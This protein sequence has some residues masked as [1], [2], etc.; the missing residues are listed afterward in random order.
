MAYTFLGTYT[1][2]CTNIYGGTLDNNVFKVDVYYEQS[3][4]NNTTSLQ[5][6]PY[7]IKSG[8]QGE[9]VTWYFKVDG[10]DYY[11]VQVQK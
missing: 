5:L 3:I 7:V 11:Y 9:S 1:G 2:T 10:Q 4:V 6:K 8:G